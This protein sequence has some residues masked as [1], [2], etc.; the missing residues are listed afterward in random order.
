MANFCLENRNFSEISPR[1][2]EIFLTR[3][4]DPHISNQIDAAESD[5]PVV[6]PTTSPQIGL[7]KFKRE[8]CSAIFRM[9]P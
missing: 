1:K 8:M 4:H 7:R 9:T 6:H 5:Y 2:I 3:I